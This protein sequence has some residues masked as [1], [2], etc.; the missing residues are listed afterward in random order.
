MPLIQHVEPGGEKFLPFARKKIA[1]LHDE[2]VT[3]G[4]GA[5]NKVIFGD[6]GTTIHLNSVS[7]GQ[8]QFRDHIRITG[9]TGASYWVEQ[10][11]EQDLWS[12]APAV[13]PWVGTAVVW[14]SVVQH[15]TYPYLTS[16]PNVYETKHQ[17]VICRYCRRVAEY[18]WLETS[19]YGTN[20]EF[21]LAQLVSSTE[22]TVTIKYPPSTTLY[23]VVGI[24]VLGSGAE[25]PLVP[26]RTIPV[27]IMRSDTVYTFPISAYLGALDEEGE[28]S[29]VGAVIGRLVSFNESTGIARFKPVKEGTAGL[30]IAPRRNIVKTGEYATTNTYNGTDVVTYAYADTG[31]RTSSTYS[32]A[33][34]RTEAEANLWGKFTDDLGPR[35]VWAGGGSWTGYAEQTQT[36]TLTLNGVV[37]QTMTATAGITQTATTDTIT[38]DWGWQSGY[39]KAGTYARGR[40]VY[41]GYVIGEL[42]LAAQLSRLAAINNARDQRAWDA[43]NVARVKVWLDFILAE[44]D[45]KRFGTDLGTSPD[46]RHS[47]GDEFDVNELR[48]HPTYQ[49]DKILIFPVRN[50]ATFLLGDGHGG[51]SVPYAFNS[52]YQAIANLS[53]IAGT[54]FSPPADPGPVPATSYT[55]QPPFEVVWNAQ[56]RAFTISG[57]RPQFENLYFSLDT[58]LSAGVLVGNTPV[59][60]GLRGYFGLYYAKG[61]KTESDASFGVYTASTTDAHMRNVCIGVTGLPSL[62]YP[63]YSALFAP[64]RGAYYRRSAIHIQ[65]YGAYSVTQSFMIN[66]E[67]D[68]LDPAYPLVSEI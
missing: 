38:G 33:A 56:T 68:I 18:S 21:P 54:T 11:P 3:T 12:I 27:M 60:L 40:A 19:V 25:D 1:Q 50:K 20:V 10:R 46:V 13:R 39:I 23:T 42:P 36:Y 34:L 44:I 57:K 22:N 29:G 9:G 47:A 66:S 28:Y 4:A 41:D 45:K 65:T 58:N 35:P 7:F 37:V 49:F 15:I 6:E 43:A 16:D 55:V 59:S 67:P 63:A 61:A 31:G 26:G 30:P 14:G 8:G 5:L 32:T 2:L 48:T 62:A 53:G 17:L 52:S 64:T 51:A 24:L